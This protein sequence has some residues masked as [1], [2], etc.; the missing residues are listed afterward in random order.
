VSVSGVHTA[1]RADGATHDLTLTDDAT[2]T[3]TH[4]D[5]VAGDAI[6]LRLIIRPE[7]HGLDWGGTITWATGAEPDVPT[8]LGAFLTVGLL[9]VDDGTTWQGYV[10]DSD[11][12]AVPE[13]ATTV[14]DETGWGVT[15][16]VGTSLDY[17]RADHTHGTQDEPAPGGGGA[18]APIL[19]S[20]DHSV[21][22][23][24]GDLLQTEEGDDLLYFDGG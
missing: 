16:A 10:A 12:V 23:V 24:F 17:A 3:P 18:F 19:I 21:P 8:A 2:I 13:P 7:G 5:P 11:A 15:P 14:E 1:D 22:L 4:S 6:D 9:S 20:D